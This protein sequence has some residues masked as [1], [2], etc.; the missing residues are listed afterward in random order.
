MK[1]NFKSPKPDAV[2]LLVFDILQEVNQ[3]GGYSNLLLPSALTDSKFDQRDKGFATELLYGTLRMQGRHDYIAAQISDRPWSEVDSGIVDVIRMG[4][5]QLFEMRVATHAAVSA[6]VELARKVLGESKASFVN[7]MLRKM[8]AQS[9]DEWMQPVHAVKD[10]VNRL[11]ILHSHP[12]WIVSAYFDL[13]KDFTEVEAALIANNI[14]ASPTLV[15]W[16]GRSSKQEL[17]ELGGAPTNYSD[18]GIKFDGIP[19]SLEPIRR[20]RAGVQDEGSQLVAQIFAK[21]ASDSPRWLDLCAGPGG[22]AAL[23]SA[24]AQETGHE[25]TANE[26]SE[27]R[28]E[29]VRQVVA[30]ARVWVGDGRDIASHEESFDAILADVPCTG[31][32]ALRRR[33]EVR[34][35][36][37]VTD[38]RELTQI[39]RELSS[40][41]ISVLNAGGFFAYATCSPH[42][43]ETSVAVAD[44]LKAHTDLEQIDIADYLPI[45]LEGALRGKSLS[46]WTHRH[47][48]DAMF[49]AVFRK[50]SA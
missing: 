16:P 41:A 19:N 12:E 37:K 2:R 32:G 50:K 22:K 36:R 38:L 14:P 15:W 43:A 6:T 30:K 31:L 33:P 46:L 11:S 49:M 5:H 7:A 28:A 29:L 39:Q 21:I 9:L 44:I 18:Y 35:R 13:L 3:R 17:I 45:G 10:D 23:L 48:S 34:W 25:F 24:I 8:S 40:S 4:A 20:R 26:V 1:S 42:F 47:Q 27:P